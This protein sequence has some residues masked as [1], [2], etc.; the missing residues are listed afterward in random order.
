MPGI[1]SVTTISVVRTLSWD[2]NTRKTKKGV[3][4][5]DW[6]HDRNEASYAFLYK[7]TVAGNT[8]WSSRSFFDRMESALM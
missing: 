6:T 1:M 3:C 7:C 5:G 8:F 2:V 4:V